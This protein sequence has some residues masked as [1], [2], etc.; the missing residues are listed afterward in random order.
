MK[1]ANTKPVVL[2]L[3]LAVVF[4]SGVAG[5]QQAR[6]V[7]RPAP[8]AEVAAEAEL[9]AARRELERAAKRVA[10]LSHGAASEDQMHRIERHVVRKPVVGVLLAPDPQSGVR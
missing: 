8:K 9:A 6:P 1:P 2:A 5:A 3:A 4:G 10:E 7:A